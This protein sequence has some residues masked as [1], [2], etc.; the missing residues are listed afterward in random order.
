MLGLPMTTEF[1]KRIPKQKFYENLTV[2]P[3]LK[4]VFIEQINTIHW[5]NKLAASTLNLAAGERDCPASSGRT[6]DH[7]PAPKFGRDVAD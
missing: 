4:R 6:R 3:E 1:N 7:T 2:T 5:R